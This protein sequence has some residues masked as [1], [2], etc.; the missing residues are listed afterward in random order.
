[1]SLFLILALLMAASAAACIEIG[2][3][4]S[5]GQPILPL[6][7][8][9]PVPWGGPDLALIA[10]F[11]LGAQFIAASAV[12]ELLAPRAAAAL[13][14]D[15]EE[16]AGAVRNQKAPLGLAIG[17]LANMA[18]N[19]SAAIFALVWI[20]WRN[21]ATAADF[22]WE[23]RAWRDDIRLG[24]AAFAAV[25]APVYGLQ[26]MLSQFVEEQHPIIEVLQRHPSATLFVLAGLSA[27]VVAPL[28]EEFFFR[29]LLQ[30]W[31]ESARPLDELSE[32]TAPSRDAQPRASAILV[33]SLLFAALHIGHGA[34]PIPLF[35]LALSLGYLY[36]RTHRLLPSATVH[37]C[38]NAC[39]F[40]L[41]CLSSL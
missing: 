34:A 4:I 32:E 31:L 37:F 29:V 35:F 40:A 17:T 27:V 2:K 19:V 30:G 1:M 9:R 13:G 20:M 28:A 6:A 36:Q 18:G 3:R 25:A 15:Q 24:A 21:K 10:A 8:R 12:A 39:S 5:V 7:P 14:M 11:Y 38:L 26:F 23:A 33:S 41:L 16:A 22:G